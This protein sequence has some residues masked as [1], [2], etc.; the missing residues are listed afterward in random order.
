MTSGRQQKTLI[1]PISKLPQENWRGVAPRVVCHLLS[2]F[3][4]FSLSLSCGCSSVFTVCEAACVCMCTPLSL[5]LRLLCCLCCP[6]SAFLLRFGRLSSA[7]HRWYTT[8]TRI[9]DKCAVKLRQ[10]AYPLYPSKPKAGHRLISDDG[11]ATETATT[12]S[13]PGH[14]R[15]R[16]VQEAEDKGWEPEG[17]AKG[18]CCR[19]S[20]AKGETGVVAATR[21]AATAA[22]DPLPGKA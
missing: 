20:A 5:L 4:S 16:D 6:A 18:C 8:C 14:E 22:A 2:L 19:Q 1:R 12:A 13:A 3:P 9:N 21:A 7:H 10:R 15:K 17:S 11:E